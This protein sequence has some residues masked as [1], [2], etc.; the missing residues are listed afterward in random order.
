MIY[1]GRIR[2]QTIEGTIEIEAGPF[3]GKYELDGA[4]EHNKIDRLN[5]GH[6]RFWQVMGGGLWR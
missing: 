1:G 2:G 3:A 6:Q 4:V 5:Q